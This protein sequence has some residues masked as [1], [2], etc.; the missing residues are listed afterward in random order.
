LLGKV[1]KEGNLPVAAANCN[2][3]RLRPQVERSKKIAGKIF[4]S[5]LPILGR[6]KNIISYVGI[7]NFY[8]RTSASSI[9]R[10]AVCCRCAI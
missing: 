10:P 1:S 3:I 6:K 7:L 8:G 2:K 4:V 5:R 9:N